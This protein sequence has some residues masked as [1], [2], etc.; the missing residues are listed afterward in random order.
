MQP[1][2]AETHLEIRG[3]IE[4][5]E[6]SLVRREL[7]SPNSV[8]SQTLEQ[9]RYVLSF[10]KLTEIRN[11]DGEDV[12]VAGRLAPHRWRVGEALKPHLQQKGEG[13]ECALHGWSFA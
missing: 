12:E 6:E 2:D 3:L 11:A 4:D 10:A 7:A 1:V 8:D 5:L 9:L 13:L